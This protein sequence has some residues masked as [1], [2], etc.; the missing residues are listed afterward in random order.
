MI[1]LFLIALTWLVLL[2]I[3]VSRNDTIT[4]VIDDDELKEDTDGFLELLVQSASRTRARIRR[5]R[6]IETQGLLNPSP[7]S[8]TS[9]NVRGTPQSA[10]RVKFNF[11][12][13]SDT[14][15]MIDAL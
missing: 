4:V 13:V 9:T 1:G 7:L 12:P 10:K 14:E 11:S 6:L 3:Y 5:D 15:K 8:E 2:G